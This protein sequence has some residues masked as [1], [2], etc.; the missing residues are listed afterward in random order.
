MSFA[1]LLRYPPFLLLC[2][3][4]LLSLVLSRVLTRRFGLLADAIRQMREGDYGQRASVG[5]HD[6]ITDVADEFNSLADR[7]QTTEEVRL[8]CVKYR[9]DMG[10]SWGDWTAS[11]EDSYNRDHNTLMKYLQRTCDEDREIVLMH[12]L[13]AT[14]KY[15]GEMID[16]MREQGYEFERLDDAPQVYCFLYGWYDDPNQRG[17]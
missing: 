8:A 7:L 2:W 14:S 17:A 3:Y 4:V 5:G 12:N 10:Y 9:K 15:A 13:E 1:N 6:E 16:W 11:T